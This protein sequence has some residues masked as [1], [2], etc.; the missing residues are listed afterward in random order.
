MSFRYNTAIIVGGLFLCAGILFAESFVKEKKKKV[1]I[2]TLRDQYQA[3]V[4]EQIKL[5]N[6][7][8]KHAA[9]VQEHDIEK[10]QKFLEGDTSE[11]KV[12]LEGKWK[13][14]CELNVK[15]TDLCGEVEEYLQ[16]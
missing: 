11:G 7:L 16:S 3:A 14:C 10:T 12:Q 1:S 9:I 15:L 13:K 6:R 2:A 4:A 8:V 5:L